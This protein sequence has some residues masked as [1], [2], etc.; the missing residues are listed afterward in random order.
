MTRAVAGRVVTNFANPAQ[1][2]AGGAVHFEF[3][4][5]QATQK[6]VSALPAEFAGAVNAEGKRYLNDAPVSTSQP[7]RGL[8]RRQKA[9]RTLKDGHHPT[10]VVTLPARVPAPLAVPVASSA[11]VVSA[12]AGA[13]VVNAA[14]SDN[15]DASSDTPVLGRTATAGGMTLRLLQPRF[16]GLPLTEQ[17]PVLVPA[18]VQP[19]VLLPDAQQCLEQMSST[20]AVADAAL[21][22]VAHILAS[23]DT[24]M[25][26]GDQVRLLFSQ[27]SVVPAASGASDSMVDDAD[28]L[29]GSVRFEGSA[30]S[31]LQS[32]ASKALSI[33]AAAFASS[34]V[35][36]PA[37]KRQHTV[38]S[39]AWSHRVQNAL[40]IVY[41][42]LLHAG[43]R[44][45]L[46]E[47]AGAPSAS[48]NV[49]I[50]GVPDSL[51][52]LHTF[53][54]LTANPSVLISSTLSLLIVNACWS[55][56]AEA[57]F[58]TATARA[59]ENADRQLRVATAASASAA[60]AAPTPSAKTP[61][62]T[63]LVTGP[64]AS[65]IVPT[66]AF[67]DG[68]VVGTLV[69]ASYED[70]NAGA[71]FRLSSGW[72]EARVTVVHG[73]V[74]LSP[75]PIYQYRVKYTSD[76]VQRDVKMRVIL[77]CCGR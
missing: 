68:I 35:V 30:M 10:W 45:V 15:V 53:A 36:R 62:A 48:A 55:S 75:T 11:Q 50:D 73:P 54:S 70:R 22:T 1:T 7:V 17:A 43:N 77:A 32:F 69:M 46:F 34:D 21:S 9:G 66:Q 25:G 20:L 16:G 58:A 65:R 64:V 42:Q 67:L 19:A 76:G 38:G 6:R 3:Q 2:K 18:A 61:T 31:P 52:V 57:E 72:Y 41:Q 44:A 27:L 74:S 37:G 23:V 4:A 8:L 39:T 63:G 12:S 26:I 49:V 29:D 56:Q 24:Y 71:A 28:I 60:S 33:T 59:G 51:P 14:S 5:E 47:A 13:P 40:R